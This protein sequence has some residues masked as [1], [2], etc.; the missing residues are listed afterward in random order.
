MRTVGIIQARMGSTRLP[1]K[2]LFPLGKRTILTYLVERLERSRTLDDIV[3]A[4]T[5]LSNDDAIVAECDKYS[6]PWFRGSE[7]DVLGRY[8]GAAI[9]TDAEV[10]VRITADNPFTDPESIDR[11]VEYIGRTG[12]DYV[13]EDRLPLGTTGEAL[14][15]EMLAFLDE[16]A[17]EPD[18][19]E[20]VTLYAKRNR[21]PKSVFLEPPEAFDRPSLQ[22]TV[23]ERSEYERVREIAG[24]LG[25]LDFD[26]ADLIQLADQLVPALV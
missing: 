11:V 2:V 19:R 26:L 9:A 13:L 22:L 15:G 1:G 24:R 20:H 18:L 10:V 5:G 7:D 23:D 21:G 17:T 8:L 6:I 16:I 14:T 25:G 4:T 3:V 12:A